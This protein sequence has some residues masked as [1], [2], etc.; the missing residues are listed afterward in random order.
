MNK[1]FF[2]MHLSFLGLLLGLY[3]T[4]IWADDGDDLAQ[5]LA[6]F[7][8]MTANFVQT[9]YDANHQIMQKNI[10]SMAI[11]RPG[12]F[13]WQVK[14]PNSQLLIADGNYLWIYDMDLSQATRQK[15]D[16]NKMTSPASLLS[17]S[18]TDLKS[19][20][21]VTHIK[22][23]ADTFKLEPKKSEDLFESI[24]LS[25]GQGKLN[26]MQLMDNLGSSSLFE[27]ANVVMNPTIDT[28]FFQFKPPKGVDV[29]HN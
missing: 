4:S 6:S 15:L 2:K 11:S 29:I 27:F 13:R 14:Q 20:F 17:G 24:E 25:F 19:R 1:F 3:A 16:K 26:R 5:Y 7:H 22:S 9:I 28:V 8:T 18:L 21:K 10:G 23:G 12:R